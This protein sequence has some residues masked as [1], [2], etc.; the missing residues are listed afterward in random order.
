ML[1]NMQQSKYRTLNGCTCKSV[2][3]ILNYGTFN[4]ARK[5]K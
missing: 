1:V 2:Y 5:K 4:K 3:D